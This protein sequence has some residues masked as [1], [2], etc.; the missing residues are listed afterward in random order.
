MRAS[1]ATLALLALAGCPTPP[2]PPKPVVASTTAPV[3]ERPSTAPSS[4]TVPATTPAT[5]AV[6]PPKEPPAT[7]AVT[8]ITVPPGWKPIPDKAKRGIPALAFASVRAYAF[9]LEN[10][11][12]PVC[13]GP[14]RE[15]GSLCDTVAAEATL[16]PSQAQDLVDLLNAK[17]TFGGGGSCF[18]PH[19]GF[20]F[21]DEAGGP[22]GYV[23]VCFMCENARSAP[24]LSK[25]KAPYGSYGISEAGAEALRALCAELG[26]PKCDARTPSD[27]RPNAIPDPWGEKR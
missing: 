1:L 7:P 19:H 26:L 10:D 17:S 13:S 12:K 20:V 16:S 2:A 23:S 3:L 25:A 15:D 8:P 27:Y 21:F 6:T 24:Q 22:V 4:A 14:L 18:L 9:D 11:G 5:A